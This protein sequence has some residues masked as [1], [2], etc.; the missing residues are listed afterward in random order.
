MLVWYSILTALFRCP[1]ALVD[2]TQDSPK[3]CKPYLTVRS[4]IAPHLEPYYETYAA[5][6]VDA[7][8]PYLEKIDKHV[9]TPSVTFGKLQYQKYG[10]PRV[11]QAKSY[12]QSQWNLTVKPQMDAIQ[13]Q[14]K[15]RYDSSLSPH[16]T[17]ALATINPYYRSGR[18][19]VLHTYD[20]YLLPAYTA[21]RPYAEQSYS[22]GHKAA[23]ETGLP[24]LQWAWGS[25]VVFF[26]RTLW[27]QVR[28]LYGENVE[29]QL[30][31]IGERLGRYRDGK[32]IFAAVEE[33]DR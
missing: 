26:D 30:V 29:P 10:A 11:D 16:V 33:F 24:Y 28:I 2:L 18:D 4:G 31:R 3:V 6:Y 17:K 1:S 8:R 20:T 32:E 9:Y 7:A 14:A 15:I 23:V 19:S 22:I 27:P 21:S 5:P 12:G 25:A 13:T